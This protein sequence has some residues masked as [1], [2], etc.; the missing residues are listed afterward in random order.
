MSERDRVPVVTDDGR[1]VCWADE[2]LARD[3]LRSRKARLFRRGGAIRMLV[4]AEG[5]VARLKL[6]GRGT[7]L[8]RTRYSH[9]HETYDNPERCW[10]LRHLGNTRA[11]FLRVLLDCAS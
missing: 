5:I 4:V 10:T 3:L 1:H 8:D 11:I 9:N 2:T 6:E 7:A